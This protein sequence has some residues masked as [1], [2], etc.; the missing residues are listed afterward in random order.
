M[1]ASEI[2]NGA[3]TWELLRPFADG[4]NSNGGMCPTGDELLGYGLVTV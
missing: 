3:A 1:P 2:E 4:V